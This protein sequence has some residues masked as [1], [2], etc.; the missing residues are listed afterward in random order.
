[1]S[2]FIVSRLHREVR[3]DFGDGHWT[4][5]PVVPEDEEHGRRLGLPAFGHRIAHERAHTLLARA[6]GRPECPILWAAAHAGPMPEDAATLEWYITAITYLAFVRAMPRAEDW[7]ALIDCQRDGID[8]G[9]VAR[10]VR[11]TV[12]RELLDRS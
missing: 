3:T 7:G 2:T 10:E 1:V 5:G 11:R 4:G 8:V 9:M 12:D 6:M